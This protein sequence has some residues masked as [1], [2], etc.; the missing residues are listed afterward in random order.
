MIAGPFFVGP[1]AL[2]RYVQAT[3]LVS[4]ARAAQILADERAR[5]RVLAELVDDVSG[6][7]EVRATRDGC[8]LW[9]GPR[10]RRL[11]YIVGPGEGERPALVTVLPTHDG[12]RAPCR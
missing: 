2:R 6:A 5:A 9:R 3:Q 4:E 11:R 7:H 1:H 8:A 10:P 12:R